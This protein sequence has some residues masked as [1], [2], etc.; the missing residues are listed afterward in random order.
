MIDRLAE[1]YGP[2]LH[3]SGLTSTTDIS[4]YIEME[5]SAGKPYT[6]VFGTRKL[7]VLRRVSVG[8]LLNDFAHFDQVISSTLK[9]ELRPRGSDARLFRPAN[10]ACICEGVALFA[11]QNERLAESR[12]E[13]A[14]KLGIQTPGPEMM[15]FWANIDRLRKEGYRAFAGDGAAWDA[16]FQLWQVYVVRELRKRFLPKDLHDRV[17]RYYGQM[18][19]GWTAFDGGL[20]RL[21]GNPSGHYNTSSDNCLAQEASWLLTLRGIRAL[22]APLSLSVYGDDSVFLIRDPFIKSVDLIDGFKSLG[23]YLEL[24]GDEVSTPYDA[25]VFIG[26]H[27]SSNEHGTGFSYDAQALTASLRWT[28]RGRSDQDYVRKLVAITMLLYYNP[29]FYD[30]R[31]WVICTVQQN[32]P[33]LLGELRHCTPERC[34]QIYNGFESFQGSLDGVSLASL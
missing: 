25:V 16:N 26:T 15:A 28:E 4:E 21:I 17:D 31:N 30:V 13:S 34:A 6:S 7:D 10:I 14:C 22:A 9:D 29:M 27:R 5:T 32:W 1:T 3:G 2:W 23:N 20:I 8:D 18:Y 33:H 12:H 19:L 11:E 24:A